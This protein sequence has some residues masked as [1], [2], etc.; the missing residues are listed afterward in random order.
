[1]PLNNYKEECGIIVEFFTCYYRLAKAPSSTPGSRNTLLP[2]SGIMKEQERSPPQVC[3][4]T[5]P[6]RDLC[7]SV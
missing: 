1:M 3:P 7:P 5:F 6:R 2:A 4:L